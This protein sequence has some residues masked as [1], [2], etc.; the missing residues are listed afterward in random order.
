MREIEIYSTKDGD[1]E[2]EVQFDGNTVW[3]TQRQLIDLFESSKANISEH[4]KHI[5]ESGELD[6]SSTVRKFRTVQ[7]E[8]K[9]KVERLLEHFNLDVIISVGYRV[10]TKRGIQFRQWATERIKAYLVKGYTVNQKRLKQLQ[11]TVKLISLGA[12]SLDLQLQEAQGLLEIIR[13]Y[14]QTFEWLYKFDS[15]NLS[16]QM[17]GKEIT[18]IIQYEEAKV[19]IS[20]L[21]KQLI[22][23]Q[24]ASTL[25]GKEKDEGFKSS[26]LS[27]VQTFAGEYLYSSIE[28]QAAHLL[29]FVVKNH[30]FSDG[31]KRIGAF[32]FILFLERNKFLFKNSGEAKINDNGLTALTLLIAQSKPEE[33]ELIIKLIINLIANDSN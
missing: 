15:N 19:A 5:F 13:N 22:I 26:L 7:M 11:Q 21:K 9:R 29:Y 27:I 2:V 24:Q 18:H 17:K 31:N 14:S 23:N 33:K 32:L 30:S 12:T 25:F 8:G 6:R 20:K 4:V 16:V 3:L 28:E 10:N 1:I